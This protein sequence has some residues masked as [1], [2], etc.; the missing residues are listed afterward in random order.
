MPAQQFDIFEGCVQ[1]RVCDRQVAIS[2]KKCDEMKKG[3]QLVLYSA[4]LHVDL[5]ND[6]VFYD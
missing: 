2:F 4:R 6:N 3:I 5:S 1:C